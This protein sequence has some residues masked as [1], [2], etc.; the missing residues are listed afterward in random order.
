MSSVIPDEINPTIEL[1]PFGEETLHPL[2]MLAAGGVL[3]ATSLQ[4]EGDMDYETFESIGT[5]LGGFDRAC[6][7][8]VGDWLLYGE[9]AFPADRYAQAAAMTGLSEQTL[10]NRVTMSRA[11]PPGRRNP[12]VSYSAHRHVSALP[13]RQQE[14]WL[15]YAEENRSTERELHAAIKLAD[16]AATTRA[17]SGE[18][19]HEPPEDGLRAAVQAMVANANVMSS[20]VIVRVDDYRA[21][22]AALGEEE[23]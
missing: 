23:A 18:D 6:R 13:A 22:L 17:G 20:R 3:T 4:L 12:R 9:G 16:G 8:W 7:W 11:I 14:R 10:L 1:V 2:V 21:V 5:M 15:H 19:Q